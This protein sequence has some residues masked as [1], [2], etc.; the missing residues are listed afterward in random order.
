MKTKNARRLNGYVVVYDPANPRAMKNSNWKGY[1]YEHIKIAGEFLGRP[2]RKKEVVHHLDG[3][4]DNN[5]TEN[6][7]VLLRS[8]HTKLHEWLKS[9]AGRKLSAKHRVNSKNTETHCV[10]CG[11]TL[12]AKQKLCCSTTCDAKRKAKNSSMPSRKALMQD[13]A[14]KMSYVV[15]G[16][17]YGVTDNAVRKWA[18]KY[19]L[20][21]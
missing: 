3:S 15:M 20:L 16:R 12:Q 19:G 11:T 2:L 17:K 13:I 21:T 10:I 5:R 1:V 14:S 6:L 4:R 9:A 8:E 18:R 7:L